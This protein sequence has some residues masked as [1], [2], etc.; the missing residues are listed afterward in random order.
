MRAIR[1]QERCD[2]TVDGKTVTVSGI[3]DRFM[4]AS[5]TNNR[6]TVTARVSQELADRLDER[7]AAEGRTKQSVVQQLL[8]KQLDLDGRDILDLAETAELLGISEHVL[9]TRIAQGDFPARRFGDTW[10]CSRTA[11]LQWLSGSDEVARRPGW[12][13]V[14]QPA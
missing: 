12:L 5:T 11:V 7:V 4:A 13:R 8:S 10:R 2:T 14:E 1:G 3:Y 6:I 9:L